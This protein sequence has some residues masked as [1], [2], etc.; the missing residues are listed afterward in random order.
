[1]LR[2]RRTVPALR[3]GAR[4]PESG[5]VLLD[6]VPNPTFVNS[7]RERLEIDGDRVADLHLW[8]VGPGHAAVIASMVSDQPAAPDAYKARLDGLQGISHVTVEV[9]R[10]VH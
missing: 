8:R 2:T 4:G 10:C 3:T 9:H 6:T 1:L 7:I 5:A